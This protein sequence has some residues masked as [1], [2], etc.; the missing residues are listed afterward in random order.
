[1]R[2]LSVA[3]LLVVL[4]HEGV[5]GQEIPLPTN[6]LKGQIVF[7][8]KGCI[9][10]HS[11][12]GYGGTAGPDLSKRQYFGSVLELASILWN[13]APQMNRKFRQMRMSRPVLTE[14]EMSDLFGL[15]YYLRYLGEPGGVAKG[16]RL[17]ESKGCITCHRVDGQGGTIGPDLQQ[18]QRYT[19]PLYMVQAMWNHQPAMQEEIKKSK[20]PYPTLTGQEVTDI[21]AYLRQA[22]EVPANIRMSPG[23][24]TKGK[25]VFK[26]K[27]CNTCHL[28]EGK[29]RI[30]G[31]N[32]SGIQLNKGVTEIASLMWNHGQVM[33][34]NMKRANI[35]WPHFEGNEMADLIAYLYFLGFEDKPGNEQKGEQVFL[36][37]G[38]SSC[39]ISGGK[40]K[41]PDLATI[42]QLDS[43][44][45]MIQ[46]MW[47]HAG[48]M[49]D[50]LI[51]QNKKWPTL[52]TDEMRDLYAV[53]RK[54]GLK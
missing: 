45:R 22:T 20:V 4:T 11:I 46:L 36:R 44:I 33:V 48:D 52:S 51:V 5:F 38:C 17:L 9:E 43:P 16:R 3:L 12:S 14:A 49:E 15:L 25:E 8:E 32:L 30:I 40:G 7:E 10:C 41:G 21:A 2:I 13:H 19:T 23:D 39:H 1:M 37:K 35:Q 42:K 53:V 24:P 31:P 18:I 6:P 50:L 28:V 29:A 26:E 47:N 34:E 27:H 54:R